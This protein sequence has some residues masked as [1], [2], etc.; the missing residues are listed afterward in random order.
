[1]APTVP[2]G[3]PTQVRAGD[4]WTWRIAYSDYPI[5]E[6]WVYSVA[7][8]SVSSAT[9][10]PLTWDEAWV[11]DDGSEWTVTIPATTTDDFLAGGYRLTAFV[12]LSSQR[13]SPYSAPLLVEADSASL[14]AGDG[15]SHARRMVAAIEEVLAGRVP[16]DVE[17]YQI[18]G[19]AL[20]RIPVK[21]LHLLRNQYRQE[22]WREANG[23]QNPIRKVSFWPL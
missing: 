2:F 12:T 5:S 23:G 14:A 1:M 21:D 16:A 7:I 3:H 13:Y 20:N 4:T 19:R 6:G 9:Q 22:A 8:T 15:I 17:S 11:T 10:E 18:N